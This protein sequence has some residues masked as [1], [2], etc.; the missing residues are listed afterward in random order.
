VVVLDEPQGSFYGGE[1]A[2]PAF[3]KMMQ[4][5]LTVERVPASSP[6]SSAATGPIP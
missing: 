2:A 5:A 3:A 4:Y 6:M 1:V